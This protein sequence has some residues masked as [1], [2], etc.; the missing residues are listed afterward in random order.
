VNTRFTLTLGGCF[1]LDFDCKNSSSGCIFSSLLIQ[2]ALTLPFAAID[3][4]LNLL[5]P[6]LLGIRCACLWLDDEGNACYITYTHTYNNHMCTYL[7]FSVQSISNIRRALSTSASYA[8]VIC[9]VEQSSKL[10]ITT[11]AHSHTRC[12]KLWLEFLTKQLVLVL[13]HKGTYMSSAWIR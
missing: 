5:R 12:R 2:Y 4:L 13:R 1:L 7:T 6:P 10:Q 9:T 3:V 8:T 11:W